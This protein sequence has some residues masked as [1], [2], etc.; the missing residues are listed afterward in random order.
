MYGTRIGTKVF[1]GKKKTEFKKTRI[2]VVD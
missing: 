1:G 2:K